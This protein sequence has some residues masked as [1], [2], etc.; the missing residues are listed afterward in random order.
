MRFRPK[1]DSPDLSLASRRGPTP[2]MTLAFGELRLLAT[3]ACRSVACPIRSRMCT[4]GGAGSDHA[5]FR[6]S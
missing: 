1:F 6:R 4:R 5:T 3:T 2:R